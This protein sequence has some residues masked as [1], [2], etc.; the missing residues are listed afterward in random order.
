MSKALILF[1]RVFKQMQK[2]AL[3]LTIHHAQCPVIP[4]QGS[5]L[6]SIS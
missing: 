1:Q 4:M 5:S 6:F 3:Q 2:T